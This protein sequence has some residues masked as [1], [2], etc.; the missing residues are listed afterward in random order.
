MKNAVIFSVT[1]LI[2]TWCYAWFIFSKPETVQYYVFSM[3][4]P[5]T[6]AL[7]INSLRYRSVKQVFRPV[8]HPLN[9]RSILFSFFYPVVF[10]GF[11]ALCVYLL[12]IAE[13]NPE[14]LSNLT[15]YPSLEVVLIGSLLMFG[16]EY[17][18]RGFLLKEIAEVK[19]KIFAAM[20]VGVVWALW[21]CPMVYGLANITQMENPLLLTII[22]MGAV[23]VFSVPFAYS[24]FI[25]G[26]ILPPML[27][28]FVWNYYNPIVLGNIYQNQPGILEGSMVLINGEGLAGIILGIIFIVWYIHHYKKRNVKIQNLR[29][30]TK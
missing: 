3:F 14:K 5:A 9:F 8:T 16:E 4:I 7:I 25:S 10:I 27:F 29:R 30:T 6:V 26:N 24:F 1:V 13:F 18:W 12:G 20:A 11:V 21:H 28:H 2:V 22:Q 17:G 15:H 23:F 19:G